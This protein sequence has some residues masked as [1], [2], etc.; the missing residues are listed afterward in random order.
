MKRI[1]ILSIIILFFSTE[2]SYA[3]SEPYIKGDI[4]PAIYNELTHFFNTMNF[5]SLLK[6]EESLGKTVLNKEYIDQLI[7]NEGY[8]A[9]DVTS[10]IIPNEL[11]SIKQ[12][13]LPFV[14]LMDSVAKW[15][16]IAQDP[17]FNSDADYLLT[18]GG[19]GKVTYYWKEK[20]QNLPHSSFYFQNKLYITVGLGI[21]FNCDYFNKNDHRCFI[22][23]EPATGST[24]K[25]S[26]TEIEW[27]KDASGI[28]FFYK[29]K[30]QRNIVLTSISSAYK[31]YV[32]TE[33]KS[34]TISME[35]KSGLIYKSALTSDSV[36]VSDS[37]V[38]VNPNPITIRSYNYQNNQF[39]FTFIVDIPDLKNWKADKI[40]PHLVKITTNTPPPIMDVVEKESGNGHKNKFHL[41]ISASNDFIQWNGIKMPSPGEISNSNLSP[42]IDLL[43]NYRIKEKP[44]GFSFGVKA[45]LGVHKYSTLLNNFNLE[46]NE[47]YSGKNGF[48]NF[49]WNYNASIDQLKTTFSAVEP[50]ILVGFVYKPS[51]RGQSLNLDLD[52][53]IGYKYSVL[54]GEKFE[55]TG[56]NATIITKGKYSDFP[57]LLENAPEYNFTTFE[58]QQITDNIESSISDNYSSL[59]FSIQPTLNLRK[60]VSVFLNLTYA[61]GITNLQAKEFCY[62]DQTTDGKII[63]G[64]P[65]YNSDG[66]NLTLSS[67]R[68]A[69]GL[70]IPLFN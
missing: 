22:P 48:G 61:Y 47:S 24:H 62:V 69:F 51:L 66:N 29:N 50:S 19:D 16:P 59:L 58:N 53:S 9:L 54:F 17:N 10:S 20:D 43:V 68:I 63:F 32:D 56:I 57:V 36:T 67:L 25:I 23:I 1:L 11:I 4:E 38:F 33:S 45:G 12:T 60:K 46:D 13:S 34:D 37:M 21:S 44:Y 52:F 7:K 55:S 49:T 8:G 40:K 2:I 30:L 70:S 15:F 3:Q 26:K 27:Q 39:Y 28:E 6:S 65:I 31:P 35:I 14:A 41:N 5:D 42:G 64:N 18:I